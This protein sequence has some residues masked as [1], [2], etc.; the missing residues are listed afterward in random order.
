[1]KYLEKLTQLP[2]RYDILSI[3][4]IVCPVYFI[5]SVTTWLLKIT[6]WGVSTEASGLLSVAPVHKSYITKGH[7]YFSAYHK[8]VICARCHSTLF[9]VF[10]EDRHFSLKDV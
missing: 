8:E 6:C 2:P 1:M 7:A 10:L 4:R 3:M 5:E 9:E